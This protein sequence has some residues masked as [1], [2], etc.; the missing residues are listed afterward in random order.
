MTVSEIGPG[1]ALD[2][3]YMAGLVRQFVERHCLDRRKFDDLEEVVRKGL[4]AAS[5]LRQEVQNRG[6]VHFFV[7]DDQRRPVCI[8]LEK[9]AGGTLD[10]AVCVA[11]HPS[12]GSE[13]VGSSCHTTKAARHALFS[14]LSQEPF[15]AKTI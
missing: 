8:T 1:Q 7:A 5:A 15:G 2:R 14:C 3:P 9:Q 4:L 13:W 10:L 12:Q 6:T 11:L